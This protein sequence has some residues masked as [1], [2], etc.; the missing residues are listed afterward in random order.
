[1]VNF[2]RGKRTI[3]VDIFLRLLDYVP[4][5]EKSVLD[6]DRCIGCGLCVSTCPSS[7]L[8]LIRKPGSEQPEVPRNIIDAFIKLSRVRGKLGPIKKIK[9]KLRSKVDRLLAEK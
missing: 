4:E 6:V 8:S 2:K 5:N 7:S 9:I 1:M 3:P